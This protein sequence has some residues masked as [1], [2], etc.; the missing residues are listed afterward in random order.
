MGIRL[1]Q[2]E[3]L[4]CPR[5]GEVMI[6][7][8]KNDFWRCPKCGGEWWEDESKLKA[9]QE[10][11]NDKLAAEIFIMQSRWSLGTRYTEVP[12]LIPIIDPSSRGSRSS[13]KKKKPPRNLFNQ[14]LTI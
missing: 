3:I 6:Y 4:H 14:Y 5:C 2:E 9:K 10:R 12:P 7:D 13:R 8:K 1:T 11:E